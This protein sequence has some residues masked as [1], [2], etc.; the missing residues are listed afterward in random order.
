MVG[1]WPDLTQISPSRTSN[2]LRKTRQHEAICFRCVFV[3][4]WLACDLQVIWPRPL[5]YM[6]ALLQ[7]VHV[8]VSCKQHKLFTIGPS[9]FPLQECANSLV[10]Q[11]R[12]VTS[13]VDA[14]SKSTWK[15]MGTMQLQIKRSCTTV[16]LYRLWEHLCGNKKTSND[17]AIQD[18]KCSTWY[19]LIK[20]ISTLMTNVNGKMVIWI[21]YVV[22]SGALGKYS[23]N[24][25]LFSLFLPFLFNF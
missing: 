20:G 5:P 18:W 3:N 17:T 25:S 2:F 14:I 10:W 4:H 23:N 22:P 12:S 15:T 13:G 16:F 19:R 24:P 1:V 21:F 11:T 7:F 9:S 6:L 8:S